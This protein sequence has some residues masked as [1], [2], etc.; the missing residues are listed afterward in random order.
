MRKCVWV[1]AALLSVSLAV[2]VMAAEGESLPH[3]HRVENFVSTETGHSGLCADCG[4]AVNE[5]HSFGEGV[6][7][8]APTCQAEGT[9][10]FSCVCGYSYEEKIP[11]LADH[12]VENWI[13]EE[14][15]HRGSCIH[16]GQSI[17]GEHSYGEGVVTTA[18]T[19]TVDGEKTFTCH[20][21]YEHKEAVAQTGHSY[22][23]WSTLGASGY[24]HV[25]ATCGEKESAEHNWDNGEITQWPYCTW[26]GSQR[27]TCRDCGGQ[28]T[29]VIPKLDHLYDNTCDVSCGR[30]GAIRRTEHK[31]E[32]QWTTNEQEHWYRCTV[33]GDKGDRDAHYPG[34]WIIDR[35]AEE[36][37]DGQRHNECMVCQRVLQ[38]EVI[39]ATGCLHGDE[40]LLEMVEPTCAKEGY[41]GNWICPR[42]GAVVYEG[43]PIPK[44]PHNTSMENQKE[45]SCT[46][47]GYT[48]D[49]VCRDCHEIVTPGQAIPKLLH[50]TT[51]Q[52][53]K[54]ATCVELGYT[55]D[56]ICRNCLA[57]IT[58]GEEIPMLSHNTEVQNQKDA[59]CTEEGYTGDEICR[60]CQTTVT[61]GSII[62]KLPHEDQLLHAKPATCAQEGYS[63]DRVCMH[64]GTVVEKGKELQPLPHRYEE[65]FCIDCMAE[66]PA[67]MKPTQAPPATEPD[68]DPQERKMSPFIVGCIA[69]L[70]V[71][72][73]G[74]MVMVIL[75]MKKK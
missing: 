10:T 51:L 43:Q 57:T 16:C 20:C 35:P 30:C 74:M 4:E 33:C 36:F 60:D 5:A 63:G 70:G 53:Q 2:P 31:Y 67:F 50:D 59:T 27:Y 69:A 65:G 54:D 46:E 64:C 45:P 49:E 71:A 66:D 17:S 25:C 73:A 21:G 47:E 22:G 38:T 8:L 41:T 32:E 28:K 13:P 37:K 62:E 55:G 12:V 23:R 15:G 42:C 40:R 26:E 44:L 39:P 14:A 72:S 29:E 68:T 75:L 52:N 1:L 24:Q 18:P 3:V 56:E 19:C 61:E 58:P 9:K 48:G 11:Q 6:V 34:A 7:T